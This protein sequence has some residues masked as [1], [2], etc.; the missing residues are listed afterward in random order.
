MSNLGE[1]FTSVLA[2]LTAV[3]IWLP[4]A[5]KSQATDTSLET[6][7]A[8]GFFPATLGANDYNQSL[9]FQVNKQ[10]SKLI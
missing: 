7:E 8:A 6:A 1:V 5:G 10:L 3:E 9:F 4:A 2:F